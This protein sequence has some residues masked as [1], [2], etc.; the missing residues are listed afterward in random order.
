M[1]ANNFEWFQNT[2]LNLSNDDSNRIQLLSELKLAISAL[3]IPQLRLITHSLQLDIIFDCLNS[4]ETEQVTIT[5][6]VLAMLLLSLEPGVVFSQYED[7][8]RRAL[9]HPTPCVKKLVIKEMQRTVNDAALLQKLG[10]QGDLLLSV[11]ACIC[12]EDMS[13]ASCAMT[14]LT[15]LGSSPVG[16][17][18][19]FSDSVLQAL[20]GAMSQRDIIRFRVYEVV[21]DV[22]VHSRE[23]LEAVHKSGL[24]PDLL[25]ELKDSDVLLQLNTLELLTKLAL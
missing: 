23:G 2:I 6:D 11:V 20:R 3:N 9:G 15:K 1:T 24:L 13:V 21:I 8:M 16:L 19:L 7:S 5:S 22:A 18:I 25:K 14:L 10:I 4:S 17:A 12:H